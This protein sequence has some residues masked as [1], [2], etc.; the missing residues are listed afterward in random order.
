MDRL[1]AAFRA[2]PRL[3]AVM[4]PLMKNPLEYRAFMRSPPQQY[5]AAIMEHQLNSN[6]FG[7]GHLRL[8]LT[9]SKEYKVREQLVRDALHCFFTARYPIAFCLCP[10]LV[11][12][13]LVWFA[14][15]LLALGVCAHV[16]Q[17]ERCH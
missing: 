3:T 6:H 17:L 2:D 8:L 14:H 4:T 11:C 15:S 13:D 5:R 9:K 10:P 7:C 12:F 16:V 1:Q